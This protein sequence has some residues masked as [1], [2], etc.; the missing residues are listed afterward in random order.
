MKTAFLGTP[1]WAVPALEALARSPHC[2]ALVVTQPSKRRGRGMNPSPSPVGEASVR[3]GIPW[4][5][6]ASV[7]VPEMM[8]M[9]GK[10]CFDTL[11]VVA[12][13]EILP[14]T[15]LELPRL[16]CVNLHFSLLPR[17]RGAAPVQWAIADGALETG[18]TSMKIEA[19]LDAG[20]VYLRERTM[21]GLDETAPALG[22][23]LAAM[24]AP[25]LLATLDGIE[26]GTAVAQP[27]D[28]GEATYARML[29]AADGWIEW[30]DTADAIA[31][32]VRAFD[33]WPGQA[34]RC[35][36]GKLKF[37]SA[38]ALPVLSPETRSHPDSVPPG[39]V[40]GLSGTA[41][42]IVCGGGTV[43][44]ALMVRPEGR[45][46]ISGAEALRGRHL[47]AGERLGG[48][49]DSEV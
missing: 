41:C 22:T 32:R 14:R 47:A 42:R 1:E 28:P 15:L 16:G 20:P 34:A 33:P 10:A 21:I 11:V 25:L 37:L 2:P 49:P 19:K 36:S 48:A 9:L 30:A 6:P 24:G 4:V 44:E 45:R 26:A 40:L 38:A 35:R 17:Y 7:R 43:L 8:A 18:V 13:G 39:T 3:L 27:Q 46:S 31:R 12:F 23:R 29:T 5:A